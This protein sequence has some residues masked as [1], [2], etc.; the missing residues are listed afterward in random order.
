[1][2]STNYKLI[3]LVI[4]SVKYL[5]KYIYDFEKIYTR[6]IVD[7]TKLDQTVIERFGPF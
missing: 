1:M 5:Y 6:E 3:Y 4:V 2:Q 7:Q